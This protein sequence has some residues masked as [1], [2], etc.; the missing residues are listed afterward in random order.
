[1]TNRLI[2]LSEQAVRDIQSALWEYAGQVKHEGL[3]DHAVL[4]E[5]YAE[6]L[7]WSWAYGED[8]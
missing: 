6:Q 7:K 3:V 5:G 8:D 2:S 1:M 4:L